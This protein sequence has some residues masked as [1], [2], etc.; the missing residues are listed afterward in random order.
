MDITILISLLIGFS[1]LILGFTL[2]GGALTSLL[3]PTAALIVFG[4]TLGAVGISFP[5]QSLKKIPKLFKI[6]FTRK[7]NNLDET[8]DFFRN[9]SFNVRKHGILI[10]ENYLA[11]TQLDPFIKKGL[12]LVVDGTNPDIVRSILTRKLEQ[13]SSRHDD[14]IEVFLS[15]GGYAPTMGIIGTVLGLVQILGSLSDPSSLGS[16]IALAFIATLYGIGSANLIWLPIANKLREL[17]KIEIKE[18][19]MIIEGILLI[20]E[21]TNTNILVDNLESFIPSKAEKSLKQEQLNN[22]F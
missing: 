9:L 4:G 8:I 6:A 22:E 13:T 2:E 5:A 19:E 14:G 10:L 18:K 21:K 12:Q 15:A 11:D 16:K 1:A 17:D 3:Q 20:Q 7:N